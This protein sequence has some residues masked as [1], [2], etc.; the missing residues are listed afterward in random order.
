MMD[1][2]SR[3]TWMEY[4][5]KMTLESAKTT[6]TRTLGDGKVVLGRRYTDQNKKYASV[7]IDELVFFNS[8]IDTTQIQMLA[9]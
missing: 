5:L 7:E 6:H 8:K 1:K 3:S 9:L 2:E 4:I